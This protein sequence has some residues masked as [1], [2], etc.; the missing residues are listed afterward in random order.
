MRLLGPLTLLL[1]AAPI[2]A[3]EPPRS[4]PAA[5]RE[6]RPSCARLAVTSPQQG[7][8]GRGFS[9]SAIVGLEFEA[10]IH[11]GY[12]V[13][14]HLLELKLY[15]PRGHL[16]QV[17]SVPFT[18]E[19]PSRDEPPRE[20]RVDRRRRPLRR[21]HTRQLEGEDGIRHR[22]SASIPVAGSWIVTNSLY[23]TWRVDAYL[24]GSEN[25]CGSRRFRV[26]P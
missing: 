14:D 21:H 15:T 2:A 12:L 18:V 10:A 19:L 26:V 20:V 6:W 16:Y 25:R 4:D 24:D 22:V 1:A 3:Q 9:A 23:G 13:E 17:L 5:A 8:Q 7:R 11:S